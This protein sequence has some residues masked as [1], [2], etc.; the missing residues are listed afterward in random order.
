MCPTARWHVRHVAAGTIPTFLMHPIPYI[1][2][3][4]STGDARGAEKRNAVGVETDE[5]PFAGA[6]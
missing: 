1:V 6:V 4:K 2:R 5:K 3:R